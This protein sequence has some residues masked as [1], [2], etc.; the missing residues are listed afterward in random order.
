MMNQ[1][2]L[3]IEAMGAV[4]D[5]LDYPSF[6]YLFLYLSAFPSALLQVPEAERAIAVD[7][8]FLLA[9]PGRKRAQPSP[10]FLPFSREILGSHQPEG[11]YR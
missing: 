9:P 1:G 8:A 2:L 3:F 11:R 4:K 6:T 10:P 7:N 5:T